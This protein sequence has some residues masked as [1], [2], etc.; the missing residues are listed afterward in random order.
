MKWES[1]A[2]PNCYAVIPK[3]EFR[4]H[5]KTFPRRTA[6]DARLDDREKVVKKCHKHRRNFQ[7]C[8]RAQFKL[9][10]MWV[11]PF[12]LCVIKHGTE[13]PSEVQVRG[14]QRQED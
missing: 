10:F 5:S 4:K 9:T 3:L 1:E 11:P 12:G 6:G 14:M 2:E 13:G 8:G 7:V